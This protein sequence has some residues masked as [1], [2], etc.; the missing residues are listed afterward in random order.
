[1][2]SFVRKHLTVK[3]RWQ[4]YQLRKNPGEL[5]IKSLAFLGTVLVRFGS[6]KLRLVARDQLEVIRHLDYR[7]GDLRL[8]CHSSWDL[9]RCKSCAKEPETVE[10]IEQFVVPGDVFYDIGSNVGAYSLIAARI[11]NGQNKVF[12][13]EPSFSTFAQLSRN[14]ALNGFEGIITPFPVALAEETKL[15]KL[16]YRNLDSGAAQHKLFDRLDH[17]S[18]QRN[19][20]HLQSVLCFQLDDLIRKFCIPRPNHLKLD[21]DGSELRVLQGSTDVLASLSLKSILVE[22]DQREASSQ[23][24]ISYLLGKKFCLH[25]KRNHAGTQIWNYVFVRNADMF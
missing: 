20:K 25:S 15:M 7:T 19:G 2:R 16:E 13:F 9:F 6:R 18:N 5:G 4:L 10:W 12:A 11:N 14:I 24:V 23:E 17:G 1:M 8:L 22:I 3:Q 21:V